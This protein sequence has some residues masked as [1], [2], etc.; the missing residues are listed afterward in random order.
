M[1]YGILATG[2]GFDITTAIMSGLNVA[3]TIFDY[4]LQHPVLS[5][6]VVGSIIGV[7]T[8]IIHSLK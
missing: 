8:G 1:P 7:G 6:F 5:L 2:E 4:V 3:G